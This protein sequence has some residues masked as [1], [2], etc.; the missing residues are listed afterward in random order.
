MNEED[1][2]LFSSHELF[3]PTHY[4]AVRPQPGSHDLTSRASTV[5]YIMSKVNIHV[6]VNLFC[7]YGHGDA[8]VKERARYQMST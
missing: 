6:N 7:H 5:D 2:F 4:K 8:V 3:P 1:K